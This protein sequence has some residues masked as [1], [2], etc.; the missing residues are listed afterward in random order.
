M[1]ILKVFTVTFLLLDYFQNS[2]TILSVL[3]F[4]SVE[5][6]VFGGMTEDVRKDLGAYRCIR[7]T[8]T[9]L[10]MMPER[11]TCDFFY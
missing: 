3:T 4:D 11:T 1:K 10:N 7:V 2:D 9:P 8:L 6:M 5:T